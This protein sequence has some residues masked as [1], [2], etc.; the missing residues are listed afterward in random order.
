MSR[1]FFSLSLSSAL[2]AMSVLQG[3]IFT[4]TNTNDSG[5]GSLR[6]AMLNAS[7]GDT[8]EFAAGAN[9]TIS[10]SSALPAIAGNLTITGNQSGGVNSTTIDGGGAVQIFFVDSGNVSI[11]NLTLN[12]GLSQGGSGGSGQAGAGGGAL[13]AGGA[14]FINTGSNVSLSNISCS[15]NAA[16]G[17][18]GGSTTGMYGES[19]GGGG[20]GGMS[21]GTGADGSFNQSTGSGGGG[22]GGFAAHGGNAAIGGGGGAGY[23]GYVAFTAQTSPYDGSGSNASITTGGDGGDG[24]D[25]SSSPGGAGG[26]FGNAGSNGSLSGGGGGGG[27]GGSNS[28]SGGAG[29]HGV[30]GAAFGAGAGG[31]GGSAGGAG[32]PGSDFSAGGGGGGASVGTAGAGGAAGFG[33]GGGGGGSSMGAGI[34]G[35][36]GGSGGFG[37]GG[38]GG[39]DASIG[40]S[41]GTLGGT[42]GTSIGGGGGGAGLGG[43][44][45]VRSGATLSYENS[46]AFSS[47]G[48]NTVTAG[49]G[50]A[51]GTASSAGTAGSAE[52][53][54][55]YYQQGSTIS[56]NAPAG[57]TAT[58]FVA[59][60]G[61][62]TLTGPGLTVLVG[63][64]STPGADVGTITM[65]SGSDVQLIGNFA[66]AFVVESSGVAELTRLSIGPGTNNGTVNV[67]GSVTTATIN[68]NYS[69]GPGAD[70]TLYVTTP[71]GSSTLET[72]LLSATGTVDGQ[73]T[74]NPDVRA[75]YFKTGGSVN[76]A[77]LF[78]Y[79]Q[80]GGSN[81]TI[82]IST[83]YPDPQIFNISHVSGSDAYYLSVNQN[84]MGPYGLNFSGVAGELQTFLRNL[85]VGDNPTMIRFYYMANNLDP[86]DLDTLLTNLGPNAYGAINWAN[87]FALAQL[88]DLVSNRTRNAAATSAYTQCTP[89]P[90]PVC[91]SSDKTGNNV[92]KEVA[93]NC[94][95]TT[96]GV[97]VWLD[98]M[99]DF[100]NQ[101][102]M[103]YMPG[104][105]TALGGVFLGADYRFSNGAGVGVGGGYSYEILNWKEGLGSAKM[106]SGYAIVYG[107]YCHPIFYLDASVLGSGQTVHAHR[108]YPL[109]TPIHSDTSH[110][111]W[112]GAGKFGIGFPIPCWDWCITPFGEEGWFYSYQDQFTQKGTPSFLIKSTHSAWSRSLLGAR[113]ER[114]F[115]LW[116]GVFVP[117]L[118]VSWLYT[119]PLT[120]NDITA[121]WTYS[122]DSLT[123][124]TTTDPISQVAPHVSLRFIK[125]D[126]LEFAI[127]YDGEY[128]SKR[129][130]NTVNFTIERRF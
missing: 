5:S 103:H 64:S 45:Y 108:N 35:G 96:E 19:A 57:T 59:G 40:G 60:E 22:G 58:Q 73:F 44:I 55:A 76:P 68:G 42:G 86:A 3:A 112:N 28:V 6:Y 43:A 49:A 113:L 117:C 14:I 48:H 18:S 78:L 74:L 120:K 88:G 124:G 65:D 38:G 109:L 12:N 121:V 24:I 56:I 62:L 123:T 27:G 30:P 9:G 4:V 130:E 61:N 26:T 79:S 17:G 15:D 106:S 13:G 67:Q 21:G 80:A 100:A 115:C 116:T 53:G 37:G 39:G 83:N 110:T 41:G 111:G 7:P 105:T 51:G 99:G 119:Y 126:R 75:L 11:N 69:Q 128:G 31:G 36:T 125:S 46:P 94:N 77:S 29:G 98:G 92:N 82:S 63:Q 127:N 122:N 52:G 50:G 47:A 1:S 8:I 32:G 54:D 33:S 93:S 107:S 72:S 114:S 129:N 91:K 25:G 81:P 87:Y 97:H 104:F 118:Q 2:V 71:F 85:V 34:A 16:K 23:S 95:L 89:V 102:Q 20:G 70:T 66:Q 90:A 10:L 84:R 101:I